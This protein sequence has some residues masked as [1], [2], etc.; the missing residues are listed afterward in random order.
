MTFEIVEDLSRADIA[1]RVHGKDPVE[2]FTAG[3]QA[4][5]SVMI[6]NS[7][8]ILKKSEVNF[9][10]KAADLDLLYYDFLSEFI[11][12]KDSEK[13]LLL[14]ERLEITRSGDGYHLSCTARGE[15]IDRSRH[16]F[17]IDIKAATMH[18]L[19]VTRDDPGYTATIV[20]DV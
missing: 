7:E 3:A 5:V 16:I 9:T 2:L 1:F 13:L 14:P 20:V 8:T 10:C 11:Y 18:N 17:T 12:Y 19:S 4:L 15:V 6:K